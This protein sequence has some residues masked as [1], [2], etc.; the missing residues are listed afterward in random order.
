MVGLSFAWLAGG[1]GAELSVRC[2]LLSV[3]A[4]MR[5]RTWHRGR[6]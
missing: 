6:C 2:G 1:L 4:L 5:W 3:S